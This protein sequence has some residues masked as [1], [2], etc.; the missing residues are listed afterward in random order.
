MEVSFP[1]NWVL[2][3]PN[4]STFAQV[5]QVAPGLQTLPLLPHGPWEMKIFPKEGRSPSLGLVM[6]CQLETAPG[7]SSIT[8]QGQRRAQTHGAYLL[9][10]PGM[11]IMSSALC[12]E[13][14][15]PEVKG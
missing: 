1:N 3:A 5:G 2:G 13:G 7:P 9:C 14:S 10:P 12:S 4:R 8:S 6:G 11:V 15:G